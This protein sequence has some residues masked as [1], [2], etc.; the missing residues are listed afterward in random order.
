MIGIPLTI[1]GV[2]GLTSRLGSWPIAS[3]LSLNLGLILWAAYGLVAAQ[4]SFRL[5]AGFNL[6]TLALCFLG[7]ALNP[8]IC[9]A[10]FILGWGFQL[11]GH[12]VYEKKN[13]AFLTNLRHFVVGPLWIYSQL[14]H[15]T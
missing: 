9:A 2:L 7:Q 10:A 8:A 11:V 3:V 4:L 14:F 12:R 5:A 15:L 1:V 13:P 6:I